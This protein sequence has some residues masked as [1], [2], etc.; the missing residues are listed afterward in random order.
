MRRLPRLLRQVASIEVLGLGARKGN[1]M[2]LKPVMTWSAAEHKARLFRVI[3]ERGTVGDGKGYSAKL[4]ASLVLKLAEWKRYADGWRVTVIG[5]SLHYRRSY[6][7][8]FV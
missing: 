6:G 2:Q 8:R 4:A 3:W 1:A 5:L 7:G